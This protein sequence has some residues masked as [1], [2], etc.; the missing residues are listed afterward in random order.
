MAHGSESFTNSS[1]NEA[2][3]CNPKSNVTSLKDNCMN[4]YFGETYSLPLLAPA[5]S[6]DNEDEHAHHLAEEHAARLQEGVREAPIFSV[7]TL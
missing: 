2:I 6:D 4:N 5:I 7:G 1:L 3:F